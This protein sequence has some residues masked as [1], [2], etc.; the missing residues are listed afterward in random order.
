[1]DI[2]Q[3]NVVDTLEKYNFITKSVLGDDVKYALT[4]DGKKIADRFQVE[5]NL[6]QRTLREANLNTD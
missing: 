4:E 5:H 2:A 3:W 6:E 1:M